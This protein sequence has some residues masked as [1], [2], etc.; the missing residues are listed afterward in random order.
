MPD[1]NNLNQFENNF[2]LPWKTKKMRLYWK[3]TRSDKTPSLFLIATRTNSSLYYLK[4]K[5]TRT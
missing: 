1:E 3:N 2:K 4:K 5:L